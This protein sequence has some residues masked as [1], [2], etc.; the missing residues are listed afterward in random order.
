M[1]LECKSCSKKFLVPDSA[2]TS[3][4]RLV[5]CS[6]CGNKWTQF[7]V[8]KVSTREPKKIKSTTKVEKEKIKSKKKEKFQKQ[9]M[10][11]VYI[12]K[13]ILKKNME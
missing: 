6:S 3:N 4:G 7:P 8:K 2:I 11:Q 10:V 12:Q 1:I 9:K 13:N 5:Q